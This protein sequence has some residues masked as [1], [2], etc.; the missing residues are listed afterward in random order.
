MGIL[1][2]QKAKYDIAEKYFRK[3]IQRLT[4]Q[5]TTSKDAEP[6][7]YLGVSLKAQGRLDEAFAAFYKA[8]WSQEWKSP[9]YFSLAEIAATKGNFADALNLVN[10]SLDANSLNSRAYGLKSAILRHLGRGTEAVKL[11]TFAKAKTDPL[12]VHFMAEQWLA[13][14]NIQSEQTLL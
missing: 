3:A 9:A 2:L 8:T 11:I 7:Y 4:A 13:T 14:K 6:L 1:N 12:D 5:Y 10:Q